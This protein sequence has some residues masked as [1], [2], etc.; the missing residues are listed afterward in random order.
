[1]Q[2]FVVNDAH[3]PLKDAQAAQFSPKLNRATIILRSL[4]HKAPGLKQEKI[5]SMAPITIHGNTIDPDDEAYTSK[6]AANTNYIYVQGF[7]L[8]NNNGKLQLGDLGAKIIDFNGTSTYTCHYLPS[9]LEP[10]RKLPFVKH[11][12]CFHK[13]F[14]ASP[15]L[16]WMLREL[17]K[18]EFAS[19]FTCKLGQ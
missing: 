19:P 1:M 17:E 13:V 11:A 2:S 3:Q 10:L 15:N 14:K 9:S 7:D 4:T 8:L 6:G 5:K 18:C 12:N 16:R